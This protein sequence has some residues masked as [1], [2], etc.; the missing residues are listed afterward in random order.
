MIKT[1]LNTSK[2]KSFQKKEL[3]IVLKDLDIISPQ[4]SIDKRN[5]IINEICDQKLL[6]KKSFSDQH[7]KEKEIYFIP[8]SNEFTSFFSLVKNGYFSHLSALMLHNL[9]EETDQSN[10][11]LNFERSARKEK[12]ELNQNNIDAAFLKEVKKS[13]KYYKAANKTVFILNGQYYNQ[14]GVIEES[15]NNQHYRYTNIERTLID[16]AIRPIY[17]GGIF[18]VLRAFKNVKSVVN[19]PLLRSYINEMDHL[20]PYEQVIGYYLDKAG[21]EMTDQNLFYTINRYN[22]SFY[23][24]HGMKNNKLN[25]KW[26]LYVPQEMVDYKC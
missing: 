5:K 10:I 24:A 19:L 21:Y 3:V 1:F 12:S 20:Y 6:L 23:L 16:V 11:Y 8:S 13:T 25:A 26:N 7:G 9:I 2:L 17:A 22:Y 4:T 14:L 15:L 18:N